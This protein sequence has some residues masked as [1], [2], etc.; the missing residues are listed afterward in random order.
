[1]NLLAESPFE[2]KFITDQRT[3]VRK[4]RRRRTHQSNSPICYIQHDCKRKIHC[5]SLKRVTDN[6]EF[7]ITANNAASFLNISHRCTRDQRAIID[8]GDTVTDWEQLSCRWYLGSSEVFGDLAVEGL[9]RF[10]RSSLSL[11]T[12][13]LESFIEAKSADSATKSEV[14][15]TNAYFDLPYKQSARSI[16]T[17]TMDVNRDRYIHDLAVVEDLSQCSRDHRR[18]FLTVPM[19]HSGEYCPRKA[20]MKTQYLTLLLSR[21]D[22]FDR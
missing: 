13:V 18:S 17:K 11:R 5:I 10:I 1:M 12:N 21:S 3:F 7:I 8:I 6:T 15:W 14:K 22:H 2:Q 9:D 20:L 4:F 16:S 19:W